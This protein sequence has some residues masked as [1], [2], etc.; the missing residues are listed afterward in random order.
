MFQIAATLEASGTKQALVNGNYS[1]RL[2]TIFSASGSSVPG[3]TSNIYS[4]SNLTGSGI[5]YFNKGDVV[6]VA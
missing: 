5:G 3:T 6:F 4:V 1:A 2:G